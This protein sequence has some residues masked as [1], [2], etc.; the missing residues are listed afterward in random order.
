VLL[1]TAA[2]KLSITGRIDR[3]DQHEQT[4]QWRVIDYKT[5]S[6]ANPPEKVHRTGS[7]NDRRWVD[8]QLPLYRRLVREALGVDGDVQLGFLALPTRLDETRF[9]PAEWTEAELVE[10]DAVIA[11]VAESIVRGEFDQIAPRP[12]AFSDDWA[13][14]CQDGLPH[15]PRHEHWSQP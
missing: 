3:I 15:L 13:G 9:L 8:L 12:P 14:I 6:T 7:K 2:G 10:A 1:D 4:R 5:S 11:R